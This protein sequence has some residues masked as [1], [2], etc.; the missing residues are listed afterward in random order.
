MGGRYPVLLFDPVGEEEGEDGELG[1]AEGG[2]GCTVDF[3]EISLPFSEEVP[4]FPF[5]EQILVRQISP[6]ER[7]Q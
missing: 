3:E 5:V 2:F 1:F 6:K 7:Y 4:E